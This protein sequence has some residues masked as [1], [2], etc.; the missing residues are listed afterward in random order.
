MDQREYTPLVQLE[1]AGSY[2]GYEIFAKPVSG[3]TQY[4]A[5]ERG[6][7]DVVARCSKLEHVRGVIDALADDKQRHQQEAGL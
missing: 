2:R 3:G 5:Y 6:G 7:I 1:F 4:I